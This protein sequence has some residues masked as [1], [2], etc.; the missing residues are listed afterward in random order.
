M[1]NK[2][3]D[4]YII[5]TDIYFILL[6]PLEEFKNKGKLIFYGYLY[7]CEKKEN[8]ADKN[9][10]KL[11]WSDKNNDDFLVEIKM[12]NKQKVDELLLTFNKKIEGLTKRYTDLKLPTS[13]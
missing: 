6:N 2:E 4:R 13:K 5:I 8:I 11:I 7:K 9:I 1:N 12:E 10:I 3:Y